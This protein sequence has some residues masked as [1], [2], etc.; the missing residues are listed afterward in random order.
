MNT[1]CKII[2]KKADC[3]WACHAGPMPSADVDMDDI[4]D[5]APDSDDDS[6]DEEP[7]TGK[8][9]LEEGDHLFMATIPCE[10]EFIQAT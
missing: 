10:A 1:E 4:P 8:D 9:L 5:L 7:Y 3:I 6:D 2:F